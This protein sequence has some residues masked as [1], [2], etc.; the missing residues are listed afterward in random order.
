MSCILSRSSDQSGSC[1]GAYVCF[2]MH[3]P[4]ALYMQMCMLPLCKK[5]DFVFLVSLKDVLK[6]PLFMEALFFFTIS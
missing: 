3:M 5:I 2:Q 4:Y 1:A 6:E